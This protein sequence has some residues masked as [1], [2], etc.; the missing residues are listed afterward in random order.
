MPE[1]ARSRSMFGRVAVLVVAA[2]MLTGFLA[3][4]LSAFLWQGRSLELVRNS[5]ALRLDAVAEEFEGRAAF[6]PDATGLASRI[7]FSER[8]LSDLAARFPDPVAVLDV[9]GVPMEPTTRPVS[10][11]VPERLREGRVTV[12]TEDGGWALVP[13]FDPDGIPAGGLLVQPIEQSLER[14]RGGTREAT[15]R[16]L[17]I[18]ALIALGSALLLGAA[19]TARL[20]QP[21]RRITARVEAIGA[22]DYADRLPVD[23][24]DELGRLAAAINSM[25][26]QVED[27]I[28]S[29]RTTDRLRRELVANIG[30]D[31]R[32]PLAALQGYLEEAERHLDAQRPEAA[33]EALAVTR[34]QSGQLAALVRDLFELSVLS[35]STRPPLRREPV[36]LAELLHHAAA[37]HT[38]A[39]ETASLTFERTI[40]PDLPTLQ[41][42]GTRLLRLLDNLLDNARRH[43][44]PGG[45]VALAAER[46]DAEVVV[47]VADTGSGMPPE[48]L[49]RVFERYYR[50]EDARTRRHEGSGLGLAIAQAVAQAHGGALTA[51]S[52]PGQGSTFTL[53][54]PIPPDAPPGSVE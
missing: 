4:G 28:D 16:A 44:P 53:R 32:T 6:E 33:A 22:G 40:P 2:Q 3:V 42:D 51:T 54:L 9:Q 35:S 39:M 21:L 11:E 17:W 37:S 31:L 10:P 34:Q 18:V 15:R 45:R 49:E 41:A 23:R 14:E 26:D 1:R 43:T 52:T 30:H 36:P 7:V 20:V 38:A 24:E 29:L 48:T 47:S 46:H 50:G 19:I 25:A 12:S 27:S 5:L 13:L 8:L